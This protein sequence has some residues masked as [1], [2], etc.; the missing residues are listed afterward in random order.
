MSTDDERIS[1]DELDR[2]HISHVPMTMITSAEGEQ[3][4]EEFLSGSVTDTIQT[5]TVQVCRE[6]FMSTNSIMVAVW[7]C[8]VHKLLARNRE[9]TEL[10]QRLWRNANFLDRRNPYFQHLYEHLGLHVER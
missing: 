3:P 7:P 10:V 4:L 1:L 9:M 6:C 5:R 8:A 2:L